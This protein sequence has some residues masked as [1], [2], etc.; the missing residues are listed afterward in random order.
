MFQIFARRSDG[1]V[2]FAFT[3]TRDAASGVAACFTRAKEFG[4]EITE[5]WAE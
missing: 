5:A 1:S 2:F 3:W 4:V